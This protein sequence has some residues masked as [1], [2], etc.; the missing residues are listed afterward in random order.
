MYSIVKKILIKF[1][2]TSGI[3]L[4]NY[5][6]RYPVQSIELRQ[7]REEK[8]TLSDNQMMYFSLLEQGSERGPYCENFVGL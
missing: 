1:E 4:V 5:R 7:S 3:H 6:R 8:K 2:K